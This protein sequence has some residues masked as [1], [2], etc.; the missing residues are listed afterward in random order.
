MSESDVASASTS[1]APLTAME[2]L[3]GCNLDNT[4]NSENTLVNLKDCITDELFRY[5]KQRV[6]INEDPLL[7]W[8]NHSIMFPK[9]ALYAMERLAANGTSV[10]SE[11]VFSK[12]GQLVNA[13]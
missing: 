3:F 9:L 6:N 7:W 12:A 11:R 8:S 4:G 1:K 2:K 13:K 10:P 5:K